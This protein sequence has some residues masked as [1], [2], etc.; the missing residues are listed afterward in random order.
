MDKP[1]LNCVHD[2][3]GGLV[4]AERAHAIGAVHAHGIYAETELGG[5]FL[6]RFA[7]YEPPTALRQSEKLRTPIASG[8]TASSSPSP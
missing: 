5:N 7:I 6:V 2:R 4:N 3:F 1:V 8:E